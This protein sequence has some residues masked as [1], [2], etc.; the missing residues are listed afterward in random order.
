MLRLM[1]IGIFVFSMSS[2]LI[3]GA[4][5]N[6][7]S[8]VT[9]TATPNPTVDT[10]A[11]LM[12]DPALEP[13]NEPAVEPGD[14]PAA[15]SES[16]DLYEKD[17]RNIDAWLNSDPT[18]IAELTSQGK[19]VLVDFWTYTCVNCLRTLPFLREWHDKYA[20]NGLVIL[21]VHAPEFDFEKQ[22]E[23]VQRAVDEEG[24]E[25]PVALD[26]DMSTWRSFRNR[27][28]PAKY[29]ID[30]D[31]EIRYT[32]FG[33]GA[34]RETELEIRQ[35]LEES[36]FEVSNIPIGEIENKA[37]DEKA[38]TVT[39]ELYG[40][41]DRNYSVYGLY[42]EQDAYYIGPDR[43]HEYTDPYAENNAYPPQK[44]LLHGLWRNEREAIVHARETTDLSDYI[45][46]KFL[47]RSANVVINPPDPGEFR[48]Y[49]EM[50]NESL[51][52]DEAGDDILFDAEG[53]SYF[54][55]NEPRMYKIVEA[56]EY[57]E[58]TLKLSSDSPNFAIFAFT[59]GIYDGGF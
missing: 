49:V 52:E 43:E 2:V 42:A 4:C 18:S 38:R 35:V 14:N 29:L 37:R 53:R 23:N 13:T 51:N 33:E 44:W 8:E 59:F 11:D 36:G 17:V 27:Y 10:T 24:I 32:H 25:W 5:G 15:R 16:I 12:H 3:W 58:E 40:G 31:G 1:L 47:G 30:T 39:R 45:A 50:D 9:D 41:Y 22:L 21:G 55:V 54:N 34:Y 28:W 26:N 48:V 57:I 7:G 46:F 19:V 6:E 56:P 20:E